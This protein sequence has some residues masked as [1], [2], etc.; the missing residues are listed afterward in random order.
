MSL[1]VLAAVHFETKCLSFGPA[2]GLLAENTTDLPMVSAVTLW[3][4]GVLCLSI[5]G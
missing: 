5:V 4:L 1:P 2:P 3:W